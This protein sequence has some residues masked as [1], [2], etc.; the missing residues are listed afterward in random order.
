[1]YAGVL[2]VPGSYLLVSVKLGTGWA[3]V[4]A[5]RGPPGAGGPPP[6]IGDEV[7]T[8]G[9]RAPWPSR[10]TAGLSLPVASTRPNRP[11]P[12]PTLQAPEGLGLH[13]YQRPC[14]AT[15]DHSKIKGLLDFVMMVL[16]NRHSSKHW[17]PQLLYTHR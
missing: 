2:R 7:C 16:D 12:S 9:V 13:H 5:D 11:W 3:P 10:R 15:S 14:S 17:R 4:S 1:M 6:Q 8:E